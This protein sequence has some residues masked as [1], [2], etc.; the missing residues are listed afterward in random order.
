MSYRISV[1]WGTKTLGALVIRPFA[2]HVQQ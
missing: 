1:C 2:G